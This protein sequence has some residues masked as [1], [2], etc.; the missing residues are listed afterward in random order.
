MYF[1]YF[2]S[3]MRVKVQNIEDN[4]PM[5]ERLMTIAKGIINLQNL[6]DASVEE[7]VGQSFFRND[8]IQPLSLD[9][10]YFLARAAYEAEDFNLAVDWLL[11]VTADYIDGTGVDF[12]LKNVLNLLSSAYFKVCL[13]MQFDWFPSYIKLYFRYAYY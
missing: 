13:V 6:Y 2:F 1:F 10:K 5:E 9:D 8:S 12:S 4:L 11:R 3:A 7:I